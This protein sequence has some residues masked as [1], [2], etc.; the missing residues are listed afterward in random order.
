VKFTQDLDV[1]HS[2]SF[3]EVKASSK[4]T[5]EIETTLFAEHQATS[6]NPKLTLRLPVTQNSSVKYVAKHSR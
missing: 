6:I 2:I 5:F 3:L 4:R 1:D